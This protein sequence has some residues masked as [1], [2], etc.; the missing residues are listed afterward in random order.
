M[1]QQG[2]K[3]HR[4]RG[5]ARNPEGSR[6]EAIALGEMTAKAARDAGFTTT[7]A[8]G[9]NAE[10]LAEAIRTWV[11]TQGVDHGIR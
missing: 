3:N 7:V 8:T 10:R 5:I 4:D 2:R 1:N 6:P 11:E 9:A